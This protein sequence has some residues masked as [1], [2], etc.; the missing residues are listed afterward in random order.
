MVDLSSDK[1]EKENRLEKSMRKIEPEELPAEGRA[2]HTMTLSYDAN[3]SPQE[4]EAPELPV[5]FNI[6][7]TSTLPPMPPSLS[8]S[9]V[10]SALERSFGSFELATKSPCSSP[11]FELDRQY[12]TTAEGNGQSFS[13]SDL[14]GSFSSSS[15]QSKTSSLAL[16]HHH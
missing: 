15:A 2:V 4:N 16:W 3:T 14:T 9:S 1:E 13:M 8:E 6:E 7:S 10:H 5:Q 12:G 11:S